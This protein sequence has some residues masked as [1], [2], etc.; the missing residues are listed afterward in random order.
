[1]IVL[2]AVGK[3]VG[4]EVPLAVVVEKY[5]PDQ[6]YV[7]TTTKSAH[8]LGDFLAY[9][10][11]MA[12]NAEIKYIQIKNPDDPIATFND[13]LSSCASADIVDITSGTKAMAS[14]LFLFAVSAK[15]RV[16]YVSGE[17]DSTTGRVLTGTERVL[18]Y[19]TSKLLEEVLHRR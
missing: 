3:G 13:I 4:S 8:R 15:A 6:I 5:R 11:H 1:M 16:T 12:E 17:R 18:E 9:V 10:D 2:G 19:D 14:A 7:L